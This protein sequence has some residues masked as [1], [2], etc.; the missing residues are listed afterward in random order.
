MAHLAHL[1]HRRSP[2]QGVK[3]SC[4]AKQTKRNTHRRKNK[5]NRSTTSKKQNGRA[6]KRQIQGFP[7]YPNIIYLNDIIN[8]RRI[9]FA[10]CGFFFGRKAYIEEVTYNSKNKENHRQY[11]P[12]TAKGKTEEKP[13]CFI[14]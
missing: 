8:R 2:A 6:V 7:L 11:K 5:K 14:K 12:T 9:F 4:G 10:L 13:T 3:R 1:A